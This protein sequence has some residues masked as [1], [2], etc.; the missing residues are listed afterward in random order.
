M[1]DVPDIKVA[2]K[3]A[4]DRLRKY[5]YL[6]DLLGI[7]NEE[8]S[9]VIAHAGSRALLEFVKARQDKWRG[10][11]NDVET[12]VK[13]LEDGSADMA[14]SNSKS[15]VMAVVRR[16]SVRL[17][18]EQMKYG[19]SVLVIINPYGINGYVDV[20][21]ELGIDT[22]PLKASIFADPDLVLQPRDAALTLTLTP[23]RHPI[24]INK[25]TLSESG[26]SIFINVRRE[27]P[28]SAT[29]SNDS[30]PLYLIGVLLRN[31]TRINASF[32]TTSRG[33]SIV[34]LSFSLYVT[35]DEAAWLPNALKSAGVG[36]GSTWGG[37]GDFTYMDIP[38]KYAR[39]FLNYVI[40]GLPKSVINALN[41]FNPRNWIIMKQA[42]EALRLL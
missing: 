26:V 37:K 12:V 36:V 27:E 34:H 25:V 29:P 8:L 15:A 4:I 20:E 21:D 5:N 31:K 2:V 14:V 13:S 41:D 35:K 6:S 22:T 1:S 42:A 11:V 32:T 3:T 16:N 19:S 7:I 17:D 23:G 40:T 30:L 18:I 9:G 24:N 33:L 39:N 38:R 28:V 10:V